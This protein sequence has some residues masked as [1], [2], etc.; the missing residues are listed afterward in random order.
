MNKLLILL[1]LS[2]LS[3]NAFSQR[4]LIDQKNGFKTIKLGSPKD[5]FNNLKLIQKP[6][7]LTGYLYSPSNLDLYYVFDKEFNK[8]VLYFDKNNSLDAIRIVKQIKGNNAY[9]NA[10]DLSSETREKLS[11]VIGVWD[12]VSPNDNSGDLFVT[13]YGQKVWI[14]V[15]TIYSILPR[16]EAH[17][18]F[19][20][21]R[22]KD[23]STGF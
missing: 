23:F 3:I 6:K 14:S 4:S 8:I 1:F 10:L 20:V 21:A 12:E 19:M 2:T 16:G 11:S 7:G 22:R 15:Q 18:V 17:S 9:K 5:S 13:W